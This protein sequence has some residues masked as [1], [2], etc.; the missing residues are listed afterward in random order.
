MFGIGDILTNDLSSHEGEALKG[1]KDSTPN[2]REV[3]EISSDEDQ[4]FVFVFQLLNRILYVNATGLFPLE[5]VDRK[6][7]TIIFLTISQDPG[8]LSKQRQRMNHQG[9]LLG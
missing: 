5:K 8:Q 4:G 6:P 2:A 3:I 1:S 7:G 9:E